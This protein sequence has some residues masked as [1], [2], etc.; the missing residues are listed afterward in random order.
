MLTKRPFG[1]GTCAFERYYPE[2]QSMFTMTHP[3]LASTLNYDIVH[4]P[5]NEFMN[6]GVGLGLLPLC[7]Y[8]AFTVYI[9][10]K[11]HR[12][13]STLF[14]PLLTFQKQSGCHYVGGDETPIGFEAMDTSDRYL[15]TLLNGNIG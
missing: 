13:R 4:S 11:G 12:I 6:V 5:F 7:L 14:Y 10:I 1:W 15:Y 2:E 3:G 8:I 9:L